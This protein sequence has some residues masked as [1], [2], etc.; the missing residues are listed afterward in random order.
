MS[1]DPTYERVCRLCDRIFETPYRYQIPVCRRCEPD[2]W[3]WQ[4]AA[5]TALRASLA[6]MPVSG[7]NWVLRNLE[8]GLMR[9]HE[10]RPHERALEWLRGLDDGEVLSL[11]GVGPVTLAAIRRHLVPAVGPCPRCGGTGL[12]ACAENAE[13]AENAGSDAV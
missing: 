5:K 4:R 7:L 6:G 3:A 12:L 1:D 9:G 2:W 8:P 10:T 13:N 11:R